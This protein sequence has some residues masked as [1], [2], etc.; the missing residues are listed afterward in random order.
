MDEKCVELKSIKKKNRKNPFSK[1]FVMDFQHKPMKISFF[2][3]FFLFRN[4]A[5]TK[6]NLEW[7]E[8]TLYA[9]CEKQNIN[10]LIWS[11]CSV[12]SLFNI[13]AM[14]CWQCLRS[15]EYSQSINATK[16]T[17]KWLAFHFYIS[18]AFCRANVK[19]CA[20]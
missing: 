5:N 17:G 15:R 10:T 12:F 3:C 11:I 13:Y 20:R 9:K 19:R 14:V 1:Q 8:H 18:C 4:A 6:K 16:M 7:T 2:S